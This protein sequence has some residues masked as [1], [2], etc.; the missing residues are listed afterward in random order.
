ML[1]EQLRRVLPTLSVASIFDIPYQ[2][3]YRD[4]IRNLIFDMDNTIVTRLTNQP[5][6]K[7]KRLF[8]HLTLD[9]FHILILSNNT[10][11]SRVIQVA[12]FLDVPAI[13]SAQKP[14]SWV[15]KKLRNQFFCQP[16]ETMF[17]GDQWVTDIWGA[18]LN[19]MKA[20]VV[21]PMGEELSEIRRLY[22]RL[23][24]QL[25]KWALGYCAR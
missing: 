17:I 9:G 11:P 24:R 7:V 13:F 8:Y 4:G 5:S 19:G 20:V 3:M 10:R 6:W 16:S 15:Y 23:E 2:Q 18:R 12:S 25:L 22:F 1:K 21:E 14:F